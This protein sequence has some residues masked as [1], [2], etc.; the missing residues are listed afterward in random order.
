MSL[1]DLKNNSDSKKNQKEFKI[2]EY[3]NG[4]KESILKLF[5]TTFGM[6]KNCKHWNWQ[7]LENG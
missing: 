5:K 4:D 3:V 6:T 1:K 7:F 2:R